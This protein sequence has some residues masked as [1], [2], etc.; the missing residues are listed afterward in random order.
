MAKG[1]IIR[2]SVAAL[3]S[4]AVLG[5]VLALIMLSSATVELSANGAPV[6]LRVPVGVGDAAIPIFVETQDRISIPGFLDGPVVRR[7]DDGNWTATWFCED[8]TEQAQ[9]Q[10]DVLNIACAGKTHSLSLET[11]PVPPAVA[12]MPA[13]VAVLSDLEG[14]IVFLDKALAALDIVDAAGNWQYGAGHLVILGDSVDRGRDIFAVLWRLH[15]LAAQ[16]SSSGGAVHVLLGNHDQYMLRTNPSRANPEHIQA[17][18]RMGGYQG[19]FAADTVIGHWLRQQPVVLKL[20][21]VLFAHAGISPAVADTGLSIAEMNDSMKAYWSMPAPVP[22]SHALDAVLGRKGVTQYRGYFRASEDVYAQASDAE[23][24]RILEHFD[25]TQI[26]VAHTVVEQVKPLYGG[27]VYAI[28]VNSD[29]SAPEVLLYED[30]IAR[31]VNIGVPRNIGEPGE[32]T[33]REFSLGDAA[34]RKLLADMYRDIRRLAALPF[35]Y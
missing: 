21:S 15:D 8:H 1:K 17:L 22:S 25:A 11:P 32:R 3:V 10:G 13:R 19:A 12:A 29:E 14:N 33:V 23:L 35:P 27:R 24:D 4:L 31:I 16:A 20:G 34:D 9:G 2:R 26:V 7:H 5:V 6:R 18:N 30:G 28:D